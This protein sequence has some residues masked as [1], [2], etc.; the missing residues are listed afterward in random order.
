MLRTLGADAVGMSTVMEVIAA[1][2]CA[3]QVLG[4]SAITNM[5]LGDENQQIDTIA[6]VLQYAALAGEKIGVVINSLFNT[7]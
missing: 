1:N 3:M 6:E 4:I 5:A 2:Q 7:S